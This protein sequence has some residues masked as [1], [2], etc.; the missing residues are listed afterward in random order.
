M[1]KE[2]NIIG[3]TFTGVMVFKYG[4]NGILNSFDL[5]DADEMTS[6]QVNWLFSRHF[7][8]K[9]PQISH[10]K[11]IKTF[12]VSEGKFD[13]SFETFW[14]AY[15]NKVKRV[16]A[17][18]AW[19]KLTDAQKIAALAGIKAYFN[20]LKRKRGIEKAHPSTY[21]NQNY[22]DSEWGSVH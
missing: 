14:N 18:K 21:L 7:P 8:Y 11:A 10:F 5:I 13:L 9:E 15:D 6:K 16:M 19:N 1:T 12:T 20:Y 2:Y 17:E 3:S 22:W 4:L